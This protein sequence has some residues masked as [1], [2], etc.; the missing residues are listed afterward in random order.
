MYR[1]WPYVYISNPFW[2]YFCV[3][4]SNFIILHVVVQFFQRHL[5]N[6]MSFFF[7]IVYSFHFCQ[8][9]ID[10]R[11]MDLFLEFMLIPLIYISVFV[12]VP[13]C[14]DDCNFVVWGQEAWSPAL[15][16]FLSIAFAI[17][18]LLYFHKKILKFCSSSVNNIIGN[19]IEIALN[20]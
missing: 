19:L 11:C 5:L 7:S 6:K 3:W 8:K 1:I 13:H 18:S 15:F 14:F 17:W 12:L 4:C 16:F 9:L 10:P 2:D 20:L